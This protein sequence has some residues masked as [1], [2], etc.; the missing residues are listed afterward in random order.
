MRWLGAVLGALVLMPATASA[1]PEL[2][3]V[4]TVQVDSPAYVDVVVP[5]PLHFFSADF[6]S[7]P[8]PEF[9]G[10]GSV[11]LLALRRLG[12]TPDGGIRDSV[13]FERLGP[14]DRREEGTSGLFS[15]EGEECEDD[16]EP[17]TKPG[18]YRLYLLSDKP[19]KATLPLP[20]LAGAVDLRPAQPAAFETHP[21][22]VFEA[23]FP[24]TAAIG[25]W[26][27]QAADG[28]EM[29]MLAWFESASASTLDRSEMCFLETGETKDGSEFGPGCSGGPPDP[30]FDIAPLGDGSYGL[31][32][33][34]SHFPGGR[35]GLGVNLT[36]LGG[37]TPGGGVAYWAGFNDNEALLPDA[38]PAPATGR[39]S[40]ASA[41]AR[42]RGGRAAFPV[43]C[44]GEGPCR[45]ALALGRSAK[46]VVLAAGS[47]ATVRVAVPARLRRALAHRPRTGARLVLRTRTATGIDETV[48]RVTLKRR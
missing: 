13:Q 24:D 5:K 2:A 35:Y 47:R 12:P 19:V 26:G 11:V 4:T 34:F 9:E 46:N 29:G 3:G 31:W 1:A 32:A 7:R 48:L 41:R 17:V 36:H 43:R 45:G 44:S 6:E 16:F 8:R 39:L 18:R 30:V 37:A 38:V 10:D 14:P 25:G 33:T 22:S 28:G 42:V 23:S 27:R 40:L 15:C 21:L 20:E